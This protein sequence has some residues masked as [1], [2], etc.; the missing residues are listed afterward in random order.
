VW[1]EPFSI[2]LLEAM[3]SGLATVA[4]VTGGSPEL[5]SD[6]E[7]SLVFPKE[8]SR[9]C[10]ERIVELCNDA[11]LYE[12]VRRAGRERVRA[13]HRLSTMVDAIESALAD[14]R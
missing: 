7:N 4:T 14:A 5:V 2:V 13:R 8:D 3:A 10:A 6:R 12:R 1:E 9:A 11:E